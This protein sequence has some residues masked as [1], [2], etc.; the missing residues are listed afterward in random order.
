MPFF[1]WIKRQANKSPAIKRAHAW[2][3]WK[4]HVLRDGF[5]AVVWTRAREVETPLGFKLT[6]GLHPAY[7]QMR[8][9]TFEP[10]ET[11][12]I[13]RLLDR[14]DR[15]IDIGANLGYYT[16][17][18]LQKGRRVLAV[19][20]QP[21]NLKGLYRNL[22]SN[23]WQDRVEVMPVALSDAPGLLTLYG[24]SGPSASLLRNWAGYSPRYSQ[25]VAVS[26][27]DNLVAGRFEGER[28]LIKID[29]EGAEYGVLRG[30]AA[31][32][33]RDVR[34]V[35]LLEVCL[36]E[37]HPDGFNPDFL[38]VFQMFWEHGYEAW[39]AESEPRLVPRD[40][41]E[42]WWAARR[43]DSGTFNYIFATRDAVSGISAL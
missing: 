23:G 27:L 2:T 17:V 16:C 39:T 15:F 4:L 9:G 35:W 32:L 19:E 29:V 40:Q 3:K 42:R 8:N 43:T 38:H 31:T 20:P 6:A 22:L 36:H 13:A 21:L 24:A 11:A 18:A 14:V 1:A 12:L 37:F 5:G 7:D 25:V 26:T 28:L 34:P 30:A 41:V 10:E 33:Q